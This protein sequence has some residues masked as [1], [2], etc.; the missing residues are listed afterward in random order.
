MYLWKNAQHWQRGLWDLDTSKAENFS[1]AVTFTA[2]DKAQMF[3]GGV[4]FFAGADLSGDV[5]NTAIFL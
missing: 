3:L 1:C 5:T 2:H 4:V